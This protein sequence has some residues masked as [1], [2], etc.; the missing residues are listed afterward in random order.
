MSN[1]RGS[2]ESVTIDNSQI[3]SSAFAVGKGAK[4]SARGA[5]ESHAAVAVLEAVDR[6]RRELDHLE[7]VDDDEAA[8]VAV[9]RGGLDGLEKEVGEGEP[10]PGRVK[11]IFDAVRSSL[12]DVASVATSV[13]SLGGA[14]QSFLG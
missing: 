6:L 2:S 4:A 7:D 11:S 3:S 10:R 14:V 8:R 13:A 1:K 12:A 9:A 5:A